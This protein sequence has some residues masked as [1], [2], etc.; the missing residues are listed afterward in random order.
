MEEG[1]EGKRE[2]QE[3]RNGGEEEGHDG[4]EDDSGGGGGSVEGAQ[5]HVGGEA[6]GDGG[7]GSC[8]V[9]ALVVNIA[10]VGDF[11]LL[12]LSM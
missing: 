1:G 9:Q 3:V 11:S 4:D 6:E 7:K 10:L 2:A 12:I 5:G 8:C